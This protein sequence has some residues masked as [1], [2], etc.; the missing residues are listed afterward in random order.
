[1]EDN[2]P[3]VDQFVTKNKVQQNINIGVNTYPS[4]N[5]TISDI[6][7]IAGNWRD[8]RASIDDKYRLNE[9]NNPAQDHEKDYGI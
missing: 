4:V 5:Q 1:M 3:R 8:D 7:A 9:I 6:I 2:H